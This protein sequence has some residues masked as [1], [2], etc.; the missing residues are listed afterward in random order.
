MII[1]SCECQEIPDTI[2]TDVRKILCGIFQCLKLLHFL[3]SQ[4]LGIQFG[5]F[6]HPDLL[7]RIIIIGIC[8][9]QS[10]HLHSG[11]I[12]SGIISLKFLH[13]LS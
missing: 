1:I 8:V 12:C 13:L 10:H 6:I 2:N 9:D 4:L 3:L 7:F 11:F 5:S